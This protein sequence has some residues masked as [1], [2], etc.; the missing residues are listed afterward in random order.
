MTIALAIG[1]VF[2]AVLGLIGLIGWFTRPRVTDT[3]S[4]SW[5]SEHN[6]DRRQQR[7]D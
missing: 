7:P 5:L 2:L 3:L 6:Y 4:D 1:M